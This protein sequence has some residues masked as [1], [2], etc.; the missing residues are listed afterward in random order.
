MESEVRLVL[1]FHT[2]RNV[3][4]QERGLLRIQRQST[5]RRGIFLSFYYSILLASSSIIL[6]MKDILNFSVGSILLPFQ[7]GF[8][9][10]FDS[11]LFLV[12]PT[13]LFLRSV[14]SFILV[15]A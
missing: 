4:L 7:S 14:L 12:Q 2:V 8:A 1:N 15:Q 13:S 10:C 6:M 5:V 3:H 11:S 9:K